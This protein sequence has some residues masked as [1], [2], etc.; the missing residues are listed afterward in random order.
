MEFNINS[1][2]SFNLK[3]YMGTWH[4][5]AHMPL[6]YQNKCDNARAEYKITP[7]GMSVRN[8][9]ITNGL[10]AFDRKGKAWPTIIPGKFRLFFNDGLPN[11]GVSDYWVLWTDYDNYSIVG[12]PNK[13]KLWILSRQKHIPYSVLERFYSRLLSEGYDTNNIIVDRNVI[14]PV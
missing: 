12:S 6:K 5:I 2:Q 9:C 7:E 3:R 4:E 8:V 13:D 11:D 1:K 14:S 10:D